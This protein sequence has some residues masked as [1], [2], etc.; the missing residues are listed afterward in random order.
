MNDKILELQKIF[1]TQFGYVT[2]ITEITDEPNLFGIMVFMVSEDKYSAVEDL[3]Y[4]LEETLLADSEFGVIALIKTVAVTKEYYMEIYEQYAQEKVFTSLLGKDKKR[5]NGISIPI[6][7]ETSFVTP[8]VFDVD[9]NIH[10]LYNKA[11]EYSQKDNN[12]I[13][14]ENDVSLKAA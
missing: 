14:N 13:D 9:I 8:S 1:E 12:I 3:V 2:K 10:N 11:T 6:I 4:D 7:F 5:H